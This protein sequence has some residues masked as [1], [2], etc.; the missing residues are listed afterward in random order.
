MSEKDA[1][2]EHV[3]VLLTIIV[4]VTFAFPPTFKFPVIDALDEHV[5]AS[6]IF[7][8]PVILAFPATVS[9]FTGIIAKEVVVSTLVT[10]YQ[11]NE[12][13]II[14]PTILIQKFFHNETKAF[15]YLLFILIY[16]PFGYGKSKRLTHSGIK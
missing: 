7:I 2:D 14:D 10:L 5:I 12:T 6:L 3:I 9:L 16:F 11:I 4:P 15:A 8:V 1:V 13:T